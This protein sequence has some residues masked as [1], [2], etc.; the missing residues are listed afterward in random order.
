MGD[1][2]DK[3]TD[4]GKFAV[5][6]AG[7]AVDA[8]KDAIEIAKL[9]AKIKENTTNI[10][11]IILALMDSGEQT[12]NT[13]IAGYYSEILEAREKIKELKEK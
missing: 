11:S 1:I 8:G 6:K 10:G 7:E 5:D 4:L 13:K 2:L 3:L 12:A 9:E